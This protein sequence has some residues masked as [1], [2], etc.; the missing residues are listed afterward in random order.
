[1]SSWPYPS[2][3]LFQFDFR[4][5]HFDYKEDLPAPL[6]ST[7]P[8]WIPGTTVSWTRTKPGSLYTRTFLEFSYGD[9][10]YD[11]TTQTG[12]P[13]TDSSSN[14][15]LF[16]VE[17]NI[18]YTF[19]SGKLLLSPYTGLGYRYWKR[20]DSEVVNSAAFVR[21]DYEWM[22]I[23][24][25]LRAVYQLNP[26]LSIEPNAAVRFMFWGRMTAY[27]SDIGYGSDPTF[28]LGDKPGYYVE[29]PIRYQLGRNWSLSLTPWYEYSA[30]GQSDPV[31]VQNGHLTYSFYEP[32]SRTHQYGFN[33]GAGY[34]F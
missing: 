26:L 20:G 11:G 2:Q 10:K 29:I 13:I 21:E 32:P 19:G 28:D 18:G 6:K 33:I 7:E 14:Q 22:Y 34:S 12:Q 24:V 8:G 4:I 31:S 27:L 25:G 17:A 23:P 5:S 16:R 30:I 9:V 1:V 15:F 3:N